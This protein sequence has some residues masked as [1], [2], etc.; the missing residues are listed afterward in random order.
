[1]PRATDRFG[2]A[3]AIVLELALALARPALASLGARHDPLGVELQRHLPGRFRLGF[4]LL[5][6]LGALV[7]AP[8][9]SPGLAKELASALRRAQLF[10]QLIAARLAVEL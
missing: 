1:M 2:V 3:P 4:R 7:L 6:Q 8:Q 5:A 9:L 10:G